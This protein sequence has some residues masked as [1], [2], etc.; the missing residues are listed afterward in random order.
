M[1]GR[2]L[3]PR[4]VIMAYCDF[5]FPKVLDDLG[6]NYQGCVSFFADIPPL[7]IPSAFLAILEEGRII[8]SGINNEK[9][10]SEFLI[11]P[12]LLKMRR[13]SRRGL[14]SR[15]E[16]PV[17]PNRGLNEDIDVRLTRDPMI[18]VLKAPVAAIVEAKNDNVWN[19][20]GQ[21][22]ATM[23]AAHMFNERAGNET[24]PITA[25]RRLVCTGSSSGFM[26]IC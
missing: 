6:L 5:T 18:S 10:R 19:G 2:Q 16:F 17:D 1:I 24:M 4:G 8:S 22:I 15:S 25:H 7:E 12:L 20:F 14:F 3:F 26:R 13:V 23:V 9:A 11:A 21:C